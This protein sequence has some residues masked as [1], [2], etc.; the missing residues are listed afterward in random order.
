MKNILATAAV[1]LSL[2]ACGDNSSNV[3]DNATDTTMGGGLTTDTSTSIM[4]PND[5]MGINRDTS[6][7]DRTRITQPA[8]TLRRRDS[9]K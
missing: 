3:N 1:V 8:D 5:T 6:R 7:S 4:N 9:T 2:V